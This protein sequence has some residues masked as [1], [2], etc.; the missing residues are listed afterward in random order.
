MSSIK[1]TRHSFLFAI[2]T[3]PN[4]SLMISKQEHRDVFAKKLN[5]P[6]FRPIIFQWVTISNQKSFNC[7]RLKYNLMK[8]PYVATL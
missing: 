3:L 8:Q 7:C 5:E 1:R 6:Y 4:Q 2:W